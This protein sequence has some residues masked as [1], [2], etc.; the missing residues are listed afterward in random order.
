MDLQIYLDQN[1]E[2]YHWVVFPLL[3]FFARLC[4]VSLGTL[5]GVLASKGKRQ[6]VPFIG[7][8]EVLI[9]LLAISQ[10]M[11][12][13]TNVMCYLAWAGGYA[14]GSYLGLL[15]EEKLALGLQ[16]VRIITNQEYESLTNAL[17]D[18]HLGYTIFDGQGARGPVKMIFTIVKRKEVRRVAD[19]IREHNPNAFFSVEDVKSASGVSYKQTPSKFS[20]FSAILPVRK[21]K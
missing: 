1:S 10:I 6:I 7:F 11:A 20:V 21:G 2:F 16:V 12:N 4:D 14:T 15:I 17:T 8:F 13:L 19:L 9:W 18:S 3:I 5:R